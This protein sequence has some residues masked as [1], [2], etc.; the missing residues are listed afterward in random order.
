MTVTVSSGWAYVRRSP[1]SPVAA[2]TR[3]SGGVRYSARSLA[4]QSGGVVAA[5]ICGWT[6]RSAAVASS[7]DWPGFSRIMI[8]SH[9]VDRPSRKPG[10][11]VSEAAPIGAYTSVAWPTSSP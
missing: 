3:V 5:R 9:Q 7:T 11:S 2:A 4:F 1:D 8:W 10:R 6:P